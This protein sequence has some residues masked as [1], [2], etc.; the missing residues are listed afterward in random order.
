MGIGAAFIVGTSSK[1]RVFFTEFCFVEIFWTFFHLSP[2]LR[3]LHWNHSESAFGSQL[4]LC[5]PWDIVCKLTPISESTTTISSPT[6]QHPT[7]HSYRIH[8][9]WT[10]LLQI[11]W[12]GKFIFPLDVVPYPAHPLIHLTQHCRH[13]CRTAL[14]FACAKCRVPSQTC[15]KLNGRILNTFSMPFLDTKRCWWTKKRFVL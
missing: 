12:R 1:R 15:S 7:P 11:P 13:R 5:R 10:H 6:R 2:S 4:H 8:P 3:P 9:Q 14:P